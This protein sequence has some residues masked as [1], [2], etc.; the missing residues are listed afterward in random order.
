M[1]GTSISYLNGITGYHWPRMCNLQKTS[2]P[3][4]VRHTCE[5][6]SWLCKVSSMYSP[7]TWGNVVPAWPLCWP[8]L[9]R[10]VYPKALFVGLPLILCGVQ[11]RQLKPSYSLVPLWP[12]RNSRVLPCHEEC[13]EGRLLPP[14][15]PCL[16]SALLFHIS[17]PFLCWDKHRDTPS[18]L[19]NLTSI[20]EWQ[21]P[22]LA[23]TS[24]V[25]EEFSQVPPF[26]LEKPKHLS[27]A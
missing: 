27:S 10:M 5:S 16:L 20:L 22:L 19:T 3:S 12:V 1:K 14:S 6:F 18:P 24:S 2:K 13:W 4:H 7:W 15:P 11:R 17:S 8:T 26:H 21:F 25:S 9:N 23:G